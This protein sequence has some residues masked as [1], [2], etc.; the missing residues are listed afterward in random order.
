MSPQQPRARWVGLVA[1]ALIAIHLALGSRYGIF[2]DELYYFACGDHLAWGYV[3]HP[4][5]IALV[6][7]LSRIAFVHWLPGLRLAPAACAAA[8]VLLA[9]EIARAMHGGAFAQLVAA[10]AVAIAPAYLVIGGFLSMNCFE[11]V[12]WSA[13]ALLAMHAG[14]GERSRAWVA[15]G[16]V[17]GVGLLAKHSSLFFGAALAAGLLATS[18]RRWLATRGPWIA[19]A[20]AALLSAPNV[21]WEI[22]HGWPTIEFLHNARVAKMVRFGPISFLREQFV[23]M[24]PVNA[25]VWGAGLAW[26]LVGERARSWRFLG[27]AWVALFVLFVA[28]GAKPY[29]LSPFYPI[30]FGAGGAAIEARVASR[31]VQGTIAAI[32]AA[33]GALVAPLGLPILSPPAYVRWSSA[34][35]L[36]AS[37]GERGETGALPQWFADQFGWEPMVT[38]IA[39]AYASLPA[40]EKRTVAIF[41]GNYGEAG[42]IDWFGASLGLPRAVSGH[43]N[44]FLWGPPAEGRGAVLIAIADRRE[45]EGLYSDIRKVDETDS[46]FA[47]PSENHRAIYVCRGPT[48]SLRDA[49][50]AIKLY[51]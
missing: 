16:M 27:V 44:Y 5:L 51:V 31:S 29:Y 21:G 25:L 11:P 17:C 40:D 36:R 30:L 10:L 37:N 9:A 4:P 2:R 42:A 33:S 41:A 50:P 48:R 18:Q 47:M 32:L 38:K 6:A 20:L 7:R 1:L 3:D 15:F 45:L 26:L 12:V 23:S 39:A 8:T 35:G 19:V 14:A 34:L 13:G 43:N 24:H 22:T 28:T 46:P 49:W